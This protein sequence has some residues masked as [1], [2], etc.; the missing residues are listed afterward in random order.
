[1]SMRPLGFVL[2]CLSLTLAACGDDSS[3]GTS[4]TAAGGSGSTGMADGTTAASTGG[5]MGTTAMGGTG[6]SGSSSGT[7]T[8]MADGGSGT[9]EGGSESTGEGL[10]MPDEPGCG[11]DGIDVP[12]IDGLDENNDGIDGLAYCSV[13]VSALGGDDGNGGLSPDAPVATLARG[14]E[15]AQGFDPPRAVLVAEGTYVETVTV[16]NGTSMYGGYDA[17]SWTRNLQ[18]NTS[19]IEGTQARTLIANDIDLPTEIDGFTI[20]ARDYVGGGQSTYGVWVRNA[21]GGLLH[22][23]YCEIVGGTAGDGADG[24]DGAPGPNGGDGMPADQGTPGAG[25]ASMCGATGG[26]GGHGDVCPS[27]N[28][29]PGSAGGD[30]TAVGAGGSAG[31][32]NC[33][34]CFDGASPGSLGGSG[35]VG[36]N[37][38]AGT[39]GSDDDGS[40]GVMGLWQAA[41]GSDASFGFNGGGGGG[42]GAGGFD[43]DPFGCEID[44]S[45]GPCSGGGG[46]GA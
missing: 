46:G 18:T 6:D 43:S 31:S 39:A 30:P 15:I 25:G 1:M 33:D 36:S 4:T 40:F 3:P 16:G 32:S 35:A 21:I 41:T 20:V 22:L 45:S 42:G 10:C 28:G 9:T 23:D 11:C 14:I 7:S 12:D 8:G 26:T 34:G 5:P 17:S 2:A 29:L 44:G 24:V 19:T 27:E 13:F 38:M 37:G